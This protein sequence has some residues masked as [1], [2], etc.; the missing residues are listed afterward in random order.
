MKLY[1]KM[2]KEPS[3]IKKAVRYVI[4]TITWATTKELYKKQVYERLKEEKEK[5]KTISVFMGDNLCTKVT[6]ELK[7]IHL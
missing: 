6:M 1:S 2:S 4:L 3:D 5:I 7:I